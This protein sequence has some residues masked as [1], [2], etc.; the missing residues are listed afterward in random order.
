MAV[1]LGP[2]GLT[3]ALLLTIPELLQL[4]VD[5]PNSH[6]QPAGGIPLFNA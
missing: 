4:G 5:S 2:A 1:L 6:N 3:V